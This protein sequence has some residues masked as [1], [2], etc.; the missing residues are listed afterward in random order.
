MEKKK[1]FRTR[2][3]GSASTADAVCRVNTP[4]GTL[5]LT[6]IHRYLRP[7][8]EANKSNTLNPLQTA[9]C[10]SYKFLHIC[11]EWL[12]N[13]SNTCSWDQFLYVTQQWSCFNI[14]TDGRLEWE[15]ETHKVIDTHTHTHTQI[16][17]PI[18]LST[19]ATQSLHG[20]CSFY[21]KS[22]STLH[23]QS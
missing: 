15:R 17:W 16:K 21:G 8:G 10:G 6:L 23:I 2:A 9:F 18:N 1:G 22:R 7:A 4:R 3:E 13:P 20:W 12:L 14:E 5:K 11:I 19:V